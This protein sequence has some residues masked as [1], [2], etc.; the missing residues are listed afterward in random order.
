MVTMGDLLEERP[1]FRLVGREAELHRLSSVLRPGGSLVAFVVGIGGIGKS[2]VLERFGATARAQGA[3]VVTLDCSAVEPTAR[4][5]LGAVG[6][7]LGAGAAL[8]EVVDRIAGLGHP[9]VLVLDTYERFVLVDTWI[10]QH[11][12]PALPANARLV[13]AGRDRPPASWR[14]VP[15]DGAAVQLLDL[16]PLDDEEAASLLR[17]RGVPESAVARLVRFTGG[18]PLALSIAAA[19]AGRSEVPAETVAVSAVVDQLTSRY[20]SGIDHSTR[21]ALDAAAVLRRTTVSLLAA[22]VSDQAPQDA[23]DRLRALPFVNSTV[24]GLT[25]HETMQQAMAG[26]L[27]AAD[28]ARHRALREVAWHQLHREL[29]AASAGDLW[30]YTADMLWLIENPV[31]REAFFPS[32][33]LG[34]SVEPAGPSDGPAIV[35]IARRT[36]TPAQAELIRRWWE[37]CPGAFHVARNPSGSVQG[38]YALIDRVD[39]PLA[40]LA[41]HPVTGAWLDDLRRRPLAPGRRA[42]LC[43]RWLDADAGEL[44][45]PSQAAM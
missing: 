15:V 45:C 40:L 3:T 14:A 39:A 34:H 24:H 26:A 12:V 25:V 4:G 44:P 17:A 38:F 31:V 5:V 35:G 22:M 42:L 27:R 30:R 11:L 1:S 21:R 29:G 9:V 18:H 10:R 36:E 16:P 7:A 8:P 6:A 2:A 41:E 23:F 13:V 37:R 32:A 33:G 43:L 28:P 19:A 20:L